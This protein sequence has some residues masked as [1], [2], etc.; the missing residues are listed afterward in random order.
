MLRTSISPTVIKGGFQAN[1]IPGD[2]LATLDIRALPDEDM[3]QFAE[4]LRQLIN[5]PAIEI[6][7]VAG[8][9]RPATAPSRV[10]TE[11]FLSLERAQKKVFPA[12]STLPQM[13]AFATDSAQL[14]AKGVQAYGISPVTTAE[15]NS[16]MHG[17]DERINIANL[18]PYLEFVWTAVLDVV[19]SR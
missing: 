7:P 14:R 9:L 10:D 5:D 16:R 19:V 1:V 17:N 4:M 2:A 11:L 3:T 18:G 12:A 8:P 6:T 13:D 15:D